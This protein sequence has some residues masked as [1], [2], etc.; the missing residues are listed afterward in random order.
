MVDIPTPETLEQTANAADNA[1]QK[2]SN[3]NS[4][5][6]ATSALF[7]GLVT[8]LETS[9]AALSNTN[10]I[11]LNAASGLSVVSSRLLNVREAFKTSFDVE[12]LNTFSGHLNKLADTLPI[13]EIK[14]LIKGMAAS[15]DNALRLQNVMFKTA[16]ATGEVGEMMDGAGVSFEKLNDRV[17][18]Q[19]QFIDNLALSSGEL[20]ETVEE[21]YG[22]L[23]NVHG[24]L[25]SQ[26]EGMSMLDATM[27]YA[28]GS[29]R[30]FKDVVEDLSIAYNKMG[31]E[32]EVALKF[33]ARMSEISNKYGIELKDVKGALTGAIDQIKTF[34][35]EGMRTGQ[36]MEG[37]VKIMNNYLG[38]LKSTGVSGSTAIS[39]IQNMTGAMMKLD[40]AQR[41]FLSQQSG[42]SG[43]LRGA[44]QIEKMI[45][46]GNA[47]EVMA[48]MQ[49]SIEQMTGGKMVSRDEAAAS[50][51]AAQRATMQR[52]MIMQGPLGALA[53]DEQGAGRIAEM[54]RARTEGK[55][56]DEELAENVLQ[57]PIEDGT[58]YQQLTANEVQRVRQLMENTRGIGD[59]HMLSLFQTSFGNRVGTTAL[60]SESAGGIISAEESARE[61]RIRSSQKAQE[62]ARMSTKYMSNRGV[63][64]RDPETVLRSR[65]AE[66]G[67]N[68]ANVLQGIPYVI[69]A[70]FERLK[71]TI[72]AGSREQEVIDAEKQRIEADIAAQREMANN[73]TDS[74]EKTKMLEEA[75]Q[76]ERLLVLTTQYTNSTE[77]LRAAEAAENAVKSNMSIVN[78]YSAEG[79][80]INPNFNRT[81]VQSSGQRLRTVA[82]NVATEGAQN[83]EE[84]IQDRVARNNA[85]EPVEVDVKVTG[86]CIDCGRK[87]EQNPHQSPPLK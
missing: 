15:A 37:V 25:T 50:E 87:M 60:N 54:F 52:Q 56:T 6:N 33:T 19:R 61:N 73:I 47:S 82:N 9:N 22:V 83:T 64:Q 59:S 45:A 24:A 77:Q 4:I 75:A 27:K 13:G 49:K 28:A 35:G 68:L 67:E 23:G 34:G 26:A 32:G 38:A 31:M 36:V 63:V 58:K 2:L 46:E 74:A 57:K 81:G 16:A 1:S 17:G 78:E 70:P 3:F 72:S 84:A 86:I 41:A 14:E 40:V 76:K 11:S 5:G 71:N 7:S 8:V 21:Y 29:H 65:T 53:G 66:L 20:V 55:V 79:I 62:S 39:M 30:D 42:G 10:G 80:P 51:E 18:E 48:Q 12:H 69:R 43:G 44:F 85:R